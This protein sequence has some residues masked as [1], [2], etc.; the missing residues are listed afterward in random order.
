MNEV[1]TEA[2]VLDLHWEVKVN[3]LEYWRHFI[4]SHF[5]DQGMLDG[6]FPNVT[7]S[8]EHRKIVALDEYEIKRRLNKALEE[9]AKQSC[10]GVL[11]AT[12]EDESDFEVSKASARIILKLKNF[13]LKYKINEPEAPPP[14]AKDSPTID[15]TYV[16]ENQTFSNVASSTIRKN[17][18]NVID[19]IVDANDASLLISLYKNSMKM[20]E[21]NADMHKKTLKCI[22]KVT[23]EHFLRSILTNDIEAYINE[24]KRWLKTYTCSFESILEDIVTA[25]QST[26]VNSMDCY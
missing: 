4:K 10:L 20:N 26:N 24:R 11:L 21:E 6:S 15:S 17:S 13:L 23:R 1:M 7:F 5:T 19:E 16:K 2:A 9:L 25:H 22:S 8:K 18:S 3:A 14:S 12:L